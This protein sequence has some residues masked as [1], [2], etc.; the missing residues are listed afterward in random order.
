MI[1]FHAGPNSAPAHSAQAQ[2]NALL[3]A[4]VDAILLIDADGLIRGFNRAAEQVFGYRPEEV[5]GQNVTLL[6]P[7][8]HHSHHDEYLARYRRTGEARIIGIGREVSA[9]RRDG[10]VFPIDLSV[11]EI[12]DDHGPARFVGILRDISRRKHAESEAAAYRESLAHMSR[13]STM[14]EMSTGLAHEINQPLAAI[15]TYANASRRLLSLDEPDVAA[16]REALDAIAAQA[17]RASSIIEGMRTMIRKRRSSSYETISVQT[18]LDGLKALITID[19]NQHGVQ[20]AWHVDVPDARVHVDVVQIQQVLTNLLR[21]A[22]DAMEEHAGPSNRVDIHARRDAGQIHI[23]VRDYGA[24]LPTDDPDE[25][26]EPFVTHK[27][28][29][30]GIGLGICRSIVVAHG[31]ELTLANADDGDGVIARFTLPEARDEP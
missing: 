16:A 13:V 15:S 24:G 7:E 2:F 28:Q 26:M 29:G 18:L 6:M 8:P 30:L 25:L 3:D 23:S 17:K 5:L 31:G 21:N 27:A 9:R 22:I 4:A 12:V 10:S 14:A 20:L 11:G 1:D 19:A